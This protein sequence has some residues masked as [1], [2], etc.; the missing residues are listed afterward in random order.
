MAQAEVVG[1]VEH[2]AVSIAAAVDEVLACL[3]RSGHI[4]DRAVELARNQRLRRLWAEVAEE[5]D[6]GIAAS[7]LGFF[8]SGQHVLLVLDRLFYFV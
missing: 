4:H 6:K 8:D 5:D 3:F 1:A 7:V 2:A